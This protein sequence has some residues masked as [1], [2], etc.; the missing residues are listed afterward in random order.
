MEDEKIIKSSNTT[1]E[2]LSHKFNI[3]EF[4]M[5]QEHL[6]ATQ[7]AKILEDITNELVIYIEECEK[8]PSKYECYECGRN[9][10]EHFACGCERPRV[11]EYKECPVCND[12][13]EVD[14]PVWTCCFKTNTVCSGEI[15]LLDD[16]EVRQDAFIALLSA[17]LKKAEFNRPVNRSLGDV[18]IDVMC[19]AYEDADELKKATDF[20]NGNL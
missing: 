9:S 6:L 5:K 14:E 17:L 1:A 12:W 11:D 18:M 19:S 15:E 13:V 10:S 20:V 4:I 16:N 3:L 2:R 7:V 8:L